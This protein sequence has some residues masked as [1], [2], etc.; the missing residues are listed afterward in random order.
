MIVGQH[1][2]DTAAPPQSDIAM[3]YVVTCSGQQGSIDAFFIGLYG[4]KGPKGT[5]RCASL[6][7]YNYIPVIGRP[8]QSPGV[9]KGKWNLLSCC[10]GRFNYSKS[11]NISDSQL[12]CYHHVYRRKRLQFKRKIDYRPR[13]IVVQSTRYS[14][15]RYGLRS[16]LSDRH[17]ADGP[18]MLMV[19]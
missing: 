2:S 3:A 7:L 5:H 10:C 15:T 11:C 4:P 18:Q 19:C 9:I 17:L 16:Y 13:S 14:N 1:R 6:K 8:M 12:A